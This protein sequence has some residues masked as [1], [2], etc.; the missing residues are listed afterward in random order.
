MA[1]GSETF[2]ILQELVALVAIPGP[3]NLASQMQA[4]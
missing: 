3:K 1:V 2:T 4:L